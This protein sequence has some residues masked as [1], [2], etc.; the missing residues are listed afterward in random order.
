M[1]DKKPRLDPNPSFDLCRLGCSMYDFLVDPDNTADEMKD[2][3]EIEKI[4]VKW[5]HDDKGRNI[6][7]KTNGQERYPEFK[8]YKMIARTVHDHAPMSVLNDKHFSKYIVNKKQA[9]K[10]GAIMDID[11]YPSYM[12]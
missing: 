1:N 7:Y 8:L 6:M 4:I 5:C 10:G 9:H 11:S 3:C 12:D 2:L